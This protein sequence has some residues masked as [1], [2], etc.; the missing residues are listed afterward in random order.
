[1]DLLGDQ[2]MRNKKLQSKMLMAIPALLLGTE[3][4]AQKSETSKSAKK[5]GPVVKTIERVNY[6]T[7]VTLPSRSHTPIELSA[8]PTNFAAP[9]IPKSLTEYKYKAV[10]FA[11]LAA[12][13]I[14]TYKTDLTTLKAPLMDLKPFSIPDSKSTVEKLVNVEVWSKDDLR[15]FESYVMLNDL[16]KNLAAYGAFASLMKSKEI[17]S[18]SA[19]WGFGMAAYELG[20]RTQFEE[21][22]LSFVSKGSAKMKT[23]AFETL[24]KYSD[25]DKSMWVQ[26]LSDSTFENPPSNK[27]SDSFQILRALRYGSQKQVDSALRE[28]QSI[29]PKSPLYG[30]KIYHE[31]LFRYRQGKLNLALAVL[32]E[33]FEKTKVSF[34]GNKDLETRAA[35]LWG[36]LAFQNREFNRAFEAFRSVPKSNPLWPEAMME[37]ALSQILFKDYEG[38]A[39]NMFSLH[40]DFFKK[41]YSPDSYLIRSIG[42][43][44]LCQYA[45]AL[46]VV[47]DLQRKYKPILSGLEGYSKSSNPKG[48]FETIREFAQNPANP[49]VRG[50]ARPFL[51]AWAKDPAFERHQS[52]INQVEDEMTLFKDL[53]LQVVKMERDLT[54][55]IQKQS[56]KISSASTKKE[57]PEAI[58]KMKTDLARIKLEQQLLQQARK[59]MQGIRIEF[60]AEMEK[61]KDERK[62]MAALSLAEKRKSMAESLKYVLDQAEVLL[63]EIYNG[64]GEQLRFEAAGGKADPTKSAELK[65]TKENEVKWK[66]K[67]EIWEDELGHFRSSLTNVCGKETADNRN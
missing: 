21:T 25:P 54:A 16:K 26:G 50:I 6:P 55:E 10:E 8:R 33:A 31:A 62:K 44:N 63:Y 57:A 15:L 24:V 66:F 41:S 56:D 59:S 49:Q 47:K 20:L 51:F 7:E 65:G 12:P 1:M 5:A 42:Y 36:R 53:N 28:L 64:A 13:A 29:D 38:A 27:T 9:S 32:T 60:F 52:R 14:P 46:Q 35:L 11:P 23:M 3:V 48:D 43:L 67:G 30:M 22:M 39:G 58:E 34:N 45:D 61:I 19:K 2:M 17:E 40:T 4:L 18:D 37:Q